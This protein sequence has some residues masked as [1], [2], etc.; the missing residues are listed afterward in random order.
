MD[1]K[2]FKQNIRKP[3]PATIFFKEKEENKLGSLQECKIALS[4]KNPS[5][6]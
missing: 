4:L 6:H 3:K 1:A 5:S 2:F